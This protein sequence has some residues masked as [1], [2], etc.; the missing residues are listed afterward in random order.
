MRVSFLS[1]LA[2]AVLL[3]GACAG[4]NT[5]LPKAPEQGNHEFFKQ[6][7]AISDEVYINEDA[8]KSEWLGKL[9]RIY[10]APAD[11]SQM[12]VVQPYGV[13]GSDLDAWSVS[14]VERDVLQ[15]KF[16][17]AMTR[18]LEAEQAFLVVANPS[19]AQAI[20]HSEVIAVHPNQPKSVAEAGG[21]VGGAVTMSYALVDPVD[22]TVMIRMLDNKS[23][24]DIW[25]FENIVS[26][27]TAL[28]L[29][30]ESWGYQIRRGLLFLQGRLDGVLPPVILKRQS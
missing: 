26:D 19:S 14:D 16:L 5:S 21:R 12:R 10:V 17:A 1:S 20:L 4:Q 2:L 7:D 24:D 15:E 30:F 22:D 23:T 18:S 28:D 13:R 27:K 11:T 9:R 6:R 8:G 3:L 25:A 29:I